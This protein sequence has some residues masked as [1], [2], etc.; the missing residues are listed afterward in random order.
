MK[1]L[2]MGSK[3]ISEKSILKNSFFGIFTFSYHCN[4]WISLIQETEGAPPKAEIPCQH[5]G[6]PM[7]IMALY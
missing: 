7:E 5:S 4:I 2:P 3:Q 6:A 1:F